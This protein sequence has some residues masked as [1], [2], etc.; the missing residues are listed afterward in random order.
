M[1]DLVNSRTC[2]TPACNK[3]AKLQ[4]PS[5]I[6]LCIPGSYFCSQECFKGYWNEHKKQHKAAK[7]SGQNNSINTN[8]YTP[9]PDYMFSGK[10]RPWPQS[11]KRKIPDGIDKPE[12]WETGIPEFEMKS[13][14]S[15]QIQC[16]SAKE[17]EKMRETCKLARE[18]LDIG[19]KAVKVGATTD[20]IDRVVHEACIE[21][22]CYPSP[23][24]YHGFPKSCCTSINEVICHGIPDKRPLEDGDIVNLDITVFYNGYH[25]D[26]NETFFVGNVADEYKQL[27]KVTYEC[28]MQAI[29][30]VKPGVRYREVGNVIQKHAQA[31]GYSV[32]RSYCGHGINQLFHTAPSVPHYA[33]NKAIGIMK[34]GHTFTIEPMISQGTWRDETWPDQWTAVTQDGKRSAQFEQTLLVT[35]TGCEILT[36]RPEEN[37]AP[38]FL[39]QM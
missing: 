3:P 21:R 32:V 7:T 17:I 4:C 23:L 14:Q 38:H 24:N 8:S 6:K 9:W 16:L 36:I 29:D 11:P 10:L 35:E 37:G 31:H 1:A 26:L 25:G 22:K 2:E 18:V 30:I 12:Y 13:K 39:A 27:V 15:T 19:A 20:E 28:L 5:C 34:P 33:K